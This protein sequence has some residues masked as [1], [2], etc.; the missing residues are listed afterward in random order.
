MDRFGNIFV[1]D[2]GNNDIREGVSS[3]APPQNGNLTVS[4]TPSNAVIA[5]AAWQLN[6]GEFQLS[7]TTL[8]NLPANLYTL[9]FSN[10]EGYTTP[11]EQFEPVTA[12]QSATATAN[13]PIAI[14]NAG[15]VKVLIL[16]WGSSSFRG[17]MAGRWQ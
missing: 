4:L 7:G 14:P 5:G 13:Y 15:S 16:P 2:S 17:G 1:A 8:S 3:T 11:A 6:G 10:I 9:T 12:Y